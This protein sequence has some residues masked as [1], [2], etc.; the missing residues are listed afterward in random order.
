[1]R[2]T[3]CP[4]RG[5]KRKRESSAEGRE[6]HEYRKWGNTDNT[7]TVVNAWEIFVRRL[8]FANV[9][10]F[11]MEFLVFDQSA[12]QFK[13]LPESRCVPRRVGGRNLLRINVEYDE[14]Q[15]IYA[16]P[17]TVPIVT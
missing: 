1:M 3:Q 13:V 5:S 7:A 9:S 6:S 11:C 12:I 16:E 15:K 8:R 14:P 4:R 17:V 2:I 10:E